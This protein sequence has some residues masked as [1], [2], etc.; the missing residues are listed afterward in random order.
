MK[1]VDIRLKHLMKK[2]HGLVLTS[3]M[4]GQLFLPLTVSAK[5]SAPQ[6]DI[7]AK[8]AIAVD[9]KTGKIFYEKNADTPL[10]I[11]SMT[12]LITLYLILE[13][14][15]NG[16]LAWDDQVEISDHLL[17][18]SE[19][20]NLSNIPLTQ[21]KTY[22]VKDL[23]NASALVSANAA[24][25]ALAE[26]LAGSENK[27][28]DLM[29]NKLTSWGIN[30]AYIISTSGIN[31]DDAK[32]RTYPGSKAGEENLVS[33]KDM[34]IIA[35]HLVTDFP[36]IID[37]TKEPTIIFDEKSKDPIPMESTNWMLPDGPNFKEGVDGLKTGTTDL[38]GECF[39]G[40][41]EKDGTRIVTIIMNAD[42]SEKDSGARFVETSRLID[43]V[44]DN[45]TYTTLYKKGEVVG[46]QKVKGGV[47]TVT[48]V[49]LDEDIT[50]W[51]KKDHSYPITLS[52]EPLKAGLDKGKFAGTA[53]INEN[54]NGLGFVDTMEE[55]K[56][57]SLLTSQYL[58]KAKW[59]DLVS[60]EATNLLKKLFK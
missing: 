21:D 47:D 40:T 60:R 10:P 51:V 44:Y 31:N 43:Y 17:K 59:Y 32:G 57:Y 39:A 18:I 35:R 22:S 50:T 15:H 37:V 26:K 38:A 12:K 14:V 24:V 36:E 48:P 45:W 20:L 49:V 54:D 58:E 42:N 13:A 33:A 28:V 4:I 1:E 55:S 53:S 27:F 46:T 30:D 23:Y 8:A 2:I 6:F 5:E 34:A 29:R 56:H 11:A 9:A 16:K 41:F 52:K 19:D 3:L 7:A 25:T